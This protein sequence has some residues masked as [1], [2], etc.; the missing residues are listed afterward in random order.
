MTKRTTKRYAGA[1]LVILAFLYIVVLTSC[2]RKFR[3]TIIEKPPI[4]V[5]VGGELDE[6]QRK[7]FYHAL[8]KVLAQPYQE[9]HP[10]HPLGVI[11]DGSVNVNENYS[12]TSSVK[13][14]P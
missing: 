14:D 3:P 8:D 7:V 12:N 1:V 9:Y 13:I 10:V 11:I 4:R 6:A 2:A 5:V